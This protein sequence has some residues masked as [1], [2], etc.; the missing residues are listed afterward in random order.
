MYVRGEDMDVMKG[1][2]RLEEAERHVEKGKELVR[3]Q[4]EII[5]QLERDGYDSSVARD[6]LHA[7]EQ[8]QMI[9]IADRD[10]IREQL[11]H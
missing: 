1:V 2:R 8:S 6:V 10:R 4:C 7:L 9:H 3:K 5:E 11:T